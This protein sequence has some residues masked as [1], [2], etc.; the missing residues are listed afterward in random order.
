[1]VYPDHNLGD[2]TCTEHT[3]YHSR[4]AEVCLNR[5]H[6]SETPPVLI[7]E[8]MSTGAPQPVWRDAHAEKDVDIFGV[9]SKLNA[10]LESRLVYQ[11]YTVSILLKSYRPFRSP[12]NIHNIICGKINARGLGP[13]HPNLPGQGDLGDP[14]ENVSFIITHVLKI[15]QNVDVNAFLI[16]GS[17]SSILWSM[18]SV[19]C[20]SSSNQV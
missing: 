11:V 15:M 16:R 7:W 5:M 6:S 8:N 13:E 12:Q 3:M 9:W 20:H 2:T 10:Q 18:A 4:T 17:C 14:Q 19:V 1:M